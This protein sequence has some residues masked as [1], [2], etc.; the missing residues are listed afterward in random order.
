MA[1]S[2]ATLHLPTD[3]ALTMWLITYSA[4]PRFSPTRA[5]HGE[6]RNTVTSTHPATWLA[7]KLQDSSELYVLLFAIAIPEGK[8]ETIKSLRS[9]LYVY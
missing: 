6:V 9:S 3:E 1:A 4:S 7:E 2:A 8:E 5:L